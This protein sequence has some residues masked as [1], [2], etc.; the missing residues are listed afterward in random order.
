[1]LCVQLWGTVGVLHSRKRNRFDTLTYNL[2]YGQN[3]WNGKLVLQKDTNR[4]TDLRLEGVTR[5]QSS[6]G[7]WMHCK[8]FSC[9]EP[10]QMFCLNLSAHAISRK[11]TENCN[12][13]GKARAIILKNKSKLLHPELSVHLRHTTTPHLKIRI[14]FFLHRLKDTGAYCAVWRFQNYWASTLQWHMG[15]VPGPHH[16][17]N[18]DEDALS[19]QGNGTFYRVSRRSSLTDQ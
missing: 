16:V 15:T 8:K 1:M 13:L 14:R 18:K 3:L 9:L 11:W 7:T 17:S 19:L 4:D 5:G 2:W 12:H 6:S 10:P